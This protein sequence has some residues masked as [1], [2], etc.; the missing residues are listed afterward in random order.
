MARTYEEC[1]RLRRTHAWRVLAKRQ[2]EEDPVCA[3]DSTHPGPYEADHIVPLIAGGSLL[4]RSNVRTLCRRC[5]RRAGALVSSPPRS[6][7]RRGRSFRGRPR[8]Q[9][10]AALLS[11]PEGR[12]PFRLKVQK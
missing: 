6:P 2:V 9:S 1:R 5:N 10:A 3:I 7:R 8:P 11:P 12:P 4:D